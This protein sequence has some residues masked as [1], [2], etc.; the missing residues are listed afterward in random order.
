MGVLGRAG[1]SQVLI[2][3][4]MMCSLGFAADS[5]PSNVIVGSVQHYAVKRGD[6]L[7]RI[8][9]RFG[10]GQRSI[11][12]QNTL[13]VA[14]KVPAGQTLVI[15]N[16]HIVPKTLNEGILLNIPQRMLFHFQ[17]RKVD[18][19]FPVGVGRPDWPTP[20]GKFKVSHL[21]QDKTWIVPKSIQAEMRSK[22]ERVLTEVPPGPDN[23]LG[24]HWIGLSIPA[25]GIHSTIA[26]MSVYDFQSHGCI[27]AHADDA[28]I[29]Y[30]KVMPEDPG[31]IIYEPVLLAKLDDGRVYLEVHPDMYRRA[32]D[33]RDRAR[34]LI[35]LAALGSEVDWTRVEDVIQKREGIARDITANKAEQ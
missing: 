21:E 5:A 13:D 27:R 29:L 34:E 10:A 14:L 20:V 6:S 30:D 35:A 1:V 24:K 11:A 23:P 33:P 18:T 26:P 8:S 31:E 2:C 15:D 9:A 16:R 19:Y 4:S 22:G 12:S 7:R 25:V 3:T 17:D 32:G 28:A